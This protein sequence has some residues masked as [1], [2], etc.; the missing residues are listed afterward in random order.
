MCILPDVTFFIYVNV[1]RRS[2]FELSSVSTSYE[3]DITLEI[4]ELLLL[5]YLRDVFLQ[6]L[7][8]ADRC[9]PHVFTYFCFWYLHGLLS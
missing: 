2:C 4:I 3:S 6:Y 8:S 9:C 7:I 5:F 1:L